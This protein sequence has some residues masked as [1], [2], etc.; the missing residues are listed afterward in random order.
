VNEY[1]KFISYYT[2]AYEARALK[3]IE[4]LDKFK[5][6]HDIIEVPEVEKLTDDS[7]EQVWAKACKNRCTFISEMLNKYDKVVFMDSDTIVIQEPIFLRDLCNPYMISLTVRPC[8]VLGGVM[9]ANKTS[10]WFWDLVSKVDLPDEDARTTRA[11]E[12][13]RSNE[14]PL[15]IYPMP[16]PYNYV[17]WLM[18]L[19]SAIPTKEIVILHTMAHSKAIHDESWAK[20][21]RGC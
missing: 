5:L 19:E 11:I 21:H 1:P 12:I 17:P 3:L 18:A 10:K 20:W 8:G 9:W 15:Y 14:V 4:S 7:P 13:C 6:P 2:K 16:I